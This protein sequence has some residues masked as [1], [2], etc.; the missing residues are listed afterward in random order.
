[1]IK[2][3]LELDNTDSDIHRW[4]VTHLVFGFRLLQAHR[5][6][7]VV[8]VVPFTLWVADD[9]MHTPRCGNILNG[10]SAFISTKESIANSYRIREHWED[11]ISV[12]PNDATAKA[13]LG[14]CTSLPCVVDNA[15][16][17]HTHR[18]CACPCATI[19][20]CGVV[21]LCCASP[22]AYSV[23]SLSWF[24]R[25]IAKALFGTPPVVRLPCR[26]SCVV[27]N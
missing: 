3:A 20:C 14:R 27:G 4:Y 10:M 8:C 15:P 9:V 17:V 1:M 19:V 23:A 21:A 18:L 12:N 16:C 22:G 2:K 11:A 7:G 25:N 24:K 13:L 6:R 5:R 26:V